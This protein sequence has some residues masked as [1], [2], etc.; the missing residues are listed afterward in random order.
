MAMNV[1]GKDIAILEAHRFDVATSAR[2]ILRALGRSEHNL[3]KRIPLSL[4]PTTVTAYRRTAFCGWR[5]HLLFGDRGHAQRLLA[6]DSVQG[7]GALPE[8]RAEYGKGGSRKIVTV[9]AHQFQKDIS[10][11]SIAAQA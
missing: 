4:S 5:K 10:P 3:W 7:T 1:R 6:R 2:S 8:S 9:V 11:P